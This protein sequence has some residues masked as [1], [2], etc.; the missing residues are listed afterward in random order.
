MSLLTGYMEVFGVSFKITTS[1][2]LRVGD[3]VMTFARGGRFPRW[4]V[5]PSTARTL[6]EAKRVDYDVQISVVACV[7]KKN[8]WV[9]VGGFPDRFSLDRTSPCLIATK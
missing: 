1:K 6:S 7:D 9:L 5:T 4:F 8:G 2:N 3:R